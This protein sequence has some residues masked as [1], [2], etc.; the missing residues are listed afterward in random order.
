M[1]FKESNKN[2]RRFQDQFLESGNNII[3]T[4]NPIRKG[5][6]KGDKSKGLIYF[7]FNKSNKTIF[8]FGGSPRFIILK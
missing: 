2:L 5:L 6:T 8:L 4:G 1:V 7:D 3:Q